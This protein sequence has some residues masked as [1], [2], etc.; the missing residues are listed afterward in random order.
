MWE[1]T[2][3]DAPLFISE[4]NVGELAHFF[5]KFGVIE[6]ININVTDINL[7]V[8]LA[9]HTAAQVLIYFLHASKTYRLLD[10][11]LSLFKPKVGFCSP[12]F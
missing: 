4:V 3:G 10:S 7:I 5:A 12:I 1:R 11:L 6:Q 2:F 9:E 8:L